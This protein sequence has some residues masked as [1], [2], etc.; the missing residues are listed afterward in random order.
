MQRLMTEEESPTQRDLAFSGPSGTRSETALLEFQGDLLRDVRA[1]V[2]LAVD[3][4]VQA[5]SSRDRPAG[6][7]PW[8]GSGVLEH[9]LPEVPWCPWP[10]LLP[11]L[12]AQN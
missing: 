2:G 10:R 3:W 5:E 8:W 9:P 4:P 7:L 6:R 1:V 11:V 12:K